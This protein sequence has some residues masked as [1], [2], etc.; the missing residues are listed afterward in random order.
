MCQNLFAFLQEVWPLFSTSIVFSKAS[1]VHLP[2]LDSVETQY[3][4]TNLLGCVIVVGGMFYSSIV[5]Y[6]CKPLPH[7]WGTF[8]IM[9]TPYF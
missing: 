4:F 2:H 3:V 8:N 7:L 9:D 1:N 6:F 5:N